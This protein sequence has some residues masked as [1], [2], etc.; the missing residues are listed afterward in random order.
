MAAS[1]GLPKLLSVRELAERLG[2][3]E[4]TVRDWCSQ[5]RLPVTKVGRR[6]LFDPRRIEALIQ[7]WTR[8]PRE[9]LPPL[10]RI[11]AGEGRHRPRGKRPSPPGRGEG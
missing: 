7:E 3:A 2:I 6:T 11:L 4:Q 1:E 5:G 8:P 9:P 10:E